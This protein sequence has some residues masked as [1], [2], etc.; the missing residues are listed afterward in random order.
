MMRNI[1]KFFHVEFKISE[2]EDNV[3]SSDEE[4]EGE[5]KGKETNE[6]EES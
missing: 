5:E 2:C 6:G 3:Y 4:D 1:K